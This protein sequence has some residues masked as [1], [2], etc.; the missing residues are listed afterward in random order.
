MVGLK[1]VFLLP[2]V[3]SSAVLGGDPNDYQALMG[4]VHQEVLNSQDL[5]QK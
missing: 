4:Q 3:Q 2:A 1:P 5:V